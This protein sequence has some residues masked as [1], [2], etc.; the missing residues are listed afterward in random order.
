MGGVTI[1]RGEMSKV[2]YIIPLFD[3]ITH[4]KKVTFIFLP[5]KDSFPEVDVLSKFYN[6]VRDAR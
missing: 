3:H 5:E 6:T 1:H 2:F 4:C